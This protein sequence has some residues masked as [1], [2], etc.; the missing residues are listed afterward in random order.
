MSKT[1][2]CYGDSNTW[3]SVPTTSTTGRQRYDVH[4]RW[5]G[6]LR[7]TL[8]E[9]YW[10]VEEGL[11]GRTTVWEDPVSPNRNGAAYLLPCLES[12]QPLDL[13]V[14]MLGT[15]D[16]KHR[17]AKSAYDI[18]SGAGVLVEMIQRSMTAP[19]GGIPQV[20][21][22]CP[23]PTTPAIPPKFADMFAGGYETS[24]DL[25]AQ[26]QKVAET[27]AVHLLIAGEIIESSPVDGIHLA[28]EA[29]RTL[30]EA[31]AQRVKAILG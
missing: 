30:G 18:A 9:G 4:T 22:I 15:N 3:G 19:D 8:G 6:V 28:P 14:L 13:V 5:A 12:H 7:D 21:L 11:G 23:P 27:Y 1:I 25:P 2:L 16:L 24:C 26:F 29:H 10:V 20:L 17:F 31:V